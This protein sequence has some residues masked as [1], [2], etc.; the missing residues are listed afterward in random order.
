MMMNALLNLYGAVELQFSSV[1]RVTTCLK[2][3]QMSGKLHLSEKSSKRLSR[4]EYFCRIFA[5]FLHV[6]CPV[7]PTMQCR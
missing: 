3:L 1:I 4:R 5:D 2:T 6:E 7:A